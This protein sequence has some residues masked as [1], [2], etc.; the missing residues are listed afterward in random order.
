LGPF[1]HQFRETAGAI[2]ACQ[3]PL[4]RPIMRVDT[5]LVA[6]YRWRQRAKNA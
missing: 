5:R 4:N 1:L 3:L 2:L 6:V